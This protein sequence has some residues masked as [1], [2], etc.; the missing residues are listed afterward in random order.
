[1]LHYFTLVLLVL[2][3]ILHASGKLQTLLF[4]DILYTAYIVFYMN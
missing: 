2:N 1:M 3:F 4:T